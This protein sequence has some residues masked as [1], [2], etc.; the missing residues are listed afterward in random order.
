MFSKDSGFRNTIQTY[1]G[2]KIQVRIETSVIVKIDKEGSLSSGHSWSE[3]LVFSHPSTLSFHY[4][5][6]GMERDSEGKYEKG[7]TTEGGEYYV[8]RPIS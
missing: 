6:D 2:V 5:I 4:M 1:Y 8:Q 7:Y 3:C